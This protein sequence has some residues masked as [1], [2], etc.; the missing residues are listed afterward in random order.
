MGLS[1]DV[2]Q[3]RAQDSRT[4]RRMVGLSLAGSLLLHSIMLSLKIVAPWQATKPRPTEVVVVPRRTPPVEA[5]PEIKPT[6]LPAQPLPAQP[7]EQP[8]EPT[9]PPLQ[10]SELPLPTTT[11]ESAIPEGR[12]DAAVNESPRVGS[13]LAPGLGGFSEGIGL[14]RSNSPIR[15]SGGGARQGVPGG[16][17]DIAPPAAIGPS[18]SPVPPS[19]E[20][21][22]PE[23]ASR[24]AVCRRC[25]SPDYP[26]NALQAALEGRVGV[27]VDLDERGRVVEAKLTHSSGDRA[28]DQAV[29]ETVEE[30]WR[31]ENIDGGANDVPVE[32]YMTVNGS[33]L[34]QR[35]QE[36]GNQTAVEIPSAGFAAPEFSE[37]SALDPE[38]L[39]VNPTPV[40]PTPAVTTFESEI[41][42]LLDADIPPTLELAP[43]T[44]ATPQPPAALES[45]P[46]TGTASEPV[47]WEQQPEAST[48]F[49][50]PAL[51]EAGFEPA[52]AEVI[53]DEAVPVEDTPV[54]SEP[55]PL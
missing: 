18:P 34:N 53:S 42:N 27:T 47:P 28:I 22:S 46:L 13:G 37:P 36:W 35:A 39:E 40:D 11:A 45:E 41:G 31:F 48:E 38:H 4:L 19:P 5:P 1:D 43:I 17:S 52:P 55:A 20:P 12:V 49:A 25:P 26:R 32:V 33:E 10:P 15:G 7:P 30:R 6:P 3:Q 54:E 21:D 24:Y 2:D 16:T 9:L 51:P 50:E 8:L 29:L 44:P 23:D 14:N